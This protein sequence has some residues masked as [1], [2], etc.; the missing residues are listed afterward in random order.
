MATLQKYGISPNAPKHVAQSS[1]FDEL[2][3]EAQKRAQAQPEESAPDPRKTEFVKGTLLRVDCSR[4]PAAMLTV[5]TG[6]KSLRLRT[7]DYKTLLV[8]GEG[9]LSCDWKNRRV[10][11][12]YK[13]GGVAD[14]DLV[15][16]EV[17]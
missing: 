5:N 1:P 3:Q 12:N 2:E 7:A 8:I 10:S 16:I 11:V 13:P 6:A 14:G 4:A 17:Q 15:S 9:S